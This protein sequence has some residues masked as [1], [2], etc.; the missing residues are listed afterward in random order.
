MNDF[1]RTAAEKNKNR[2]TKTK[3]KSKQNNKQ[4]LFNLRTDILYGQCQMLHSINQ[5]LVKTASNRGNK[6]H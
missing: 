1:K 6:T 3:R 2:K 5:L 4:T